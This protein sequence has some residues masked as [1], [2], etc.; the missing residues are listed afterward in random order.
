VIFVIRQI[1]VTG[2]SGFIGAE[3]IRQQLRKPD[4]FTIVNLDKTG[5]HE[6]PGHLTE[7]ERHP[8]YTFHR[9]EI[10][11]RECIG[12]LLARYSIDAVVNFS[13][14]IPAHHNRRQSDPRT[15]PDIAGTQV[16]LDAARDARVYRFL[17]VLSNPTREESDLP[18]SIAG[19]VATRHNCCLPPSQVEIET[20]IRS[21]HYSFGV[22]ALITRSSDNY[23][24]YQSPSE[25]IPSLIARL[26]SNEPVVLGGAD[27]DLRDLI[28]VS[29]HCRGIDAA[30][31]L[32]R[33]GSVYQFGASAA[34]ADF[35][36]IPRLLELLKNTR[37]QVRYVT[38]C[39]KPQRNLPVDWTKSDRELG[40]QPLVSLKD[41]L[42][43]TIEWYRMNSN[44]VHDN[45][46][47]EER[48]TIP[49]LQYVN[50]TTGIAGTQSPADVIRKLEEFGAFVA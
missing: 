48:D 1:L 16:L 14:E 50:R 35:G 46:V 49:P 27:E 41:G 4:R 33:V 22:P 8:R 6:N 34:A 31:H 40:W 37:S 26:L 47:K 24:P 30:L 21:Y 19:D 28:H 36:M 12:V 23:G 25:F 18:G 13:S 17:Q 20:L 42:Q 2:G 45:I 7:F 11:D 38:D 5:V 3:F 10:R 32:G 29:D 39:L 9:A 43:D 15:H 44:W